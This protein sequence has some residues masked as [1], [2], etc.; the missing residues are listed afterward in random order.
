MGVSRSYPCSLLAAIG[1]LLIIP[2]L[3]VVLA[4][5]AG[6]RLEGIVKDSTQAVIP[7]VS[8]TA[9]N[10]G[11]NISYTSVTNETGLFVFVNL[12]PGTYSITSELQGFKRFI[13]KGVSLKVA[14]TVT[15]NIVLQAGDLA[16]EVMV[17]AATPLIDV[18]SGK[19]GSVVRAATR[20]GLGATRASTAP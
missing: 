15:I 20:N 17:S 11:T 5:T 9:T 10:E 19:I 18:T 16:T 8:V 13:N 7:G 6:A 2:S 12:P 4:Q 14:D 3:Q 1:V